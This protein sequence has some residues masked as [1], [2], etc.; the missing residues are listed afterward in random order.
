MKCTVKDCTDTQTPVTP[1]CK[2]H[3]EVWVSS[4]ERSTLSWKSDDEYNSAVQAFADRIN[5]EEMVEE[6]DIE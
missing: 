2:G 5:I 3:E 6:D 4:I 1:F